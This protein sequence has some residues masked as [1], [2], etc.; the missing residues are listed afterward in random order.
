MTGFGRGEVA[1]DGFKA[2]FELSSVNSRFLEVSIRLPRWLLAMESPL[3]A[4]VDARLSRG[5]VY[6]QLSWER[7]ESVPEQSLNEP[8]AD[9]YI[10]TLKRLAA[11]HQLPGEVNVGALVGMPDLWTTRNDAPDDRIEG[12][13]REALTLALDQLQRSRED[14]GQALAVDLKRRLARIDELL[15][16]VQTLASGVPS[17]IRDKLTARID[18]LFGSGGYDP[19]RLAQEVA[20]LAERA[21][22]TEECVRLEV[23]RRHFAAALDGSEAAGRRLNF[24]TQEMNREANTIGSKSSSGDLSTIA[25]EIKEEL[26]R[27][28]EQV[29]NI[30]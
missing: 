10:E 26:E 5:K 1:R 14:E 16:Q 24:L 23:H 28:R 29:Q 11:K 3:R 12:V 6:G 25:V 17:A 30:E 20:Y 27:I 19:Q 21:D 22:I 7:T 13:L 8:L 18:E 15:Q 2:V 9:W 4:L